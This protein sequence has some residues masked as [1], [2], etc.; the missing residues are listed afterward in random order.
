MNNIL[1]NSSG[2]RQALENWKALLN[3]MDIVKPGFILSSKYV[4]TVSNS[5]DDHIGHKE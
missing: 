4:F 1:N 5:I 2:R 3:G